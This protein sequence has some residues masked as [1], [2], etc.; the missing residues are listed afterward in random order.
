M[1]KLKRILLACLLLPG[2]VWAKGQL[3]PQSQ[4]L[5]PKQQQEYDSLIKELRCVTCPNQS[6]ADSS[7]PIAKAMQEEIYN[8]I[9]LDEPKEDIRNYLIDQYGDYI[10]YKPTFSAK[11]Y[12]LWFAPILMLIVGGF[13]WMRLFKRKS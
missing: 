1:R 6:I 12:A 13:T 2:L 9:K 8:R 4:P 10:T 3:Q 7:A 5:D 11:N